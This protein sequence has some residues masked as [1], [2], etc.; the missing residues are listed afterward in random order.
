[1]PKIKVKH[2]SVGTEIQDDAEW[3][4]ENLHVL[5]IEPGAV[6]VSEPPSGFHRITNIYYDP[7]SDEHVV[8]RDDQKI[9]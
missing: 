1:M 6:L 2:N 3:T 9:P 5:E 7:D 8:V 4:D